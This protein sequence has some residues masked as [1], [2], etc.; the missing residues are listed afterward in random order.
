MLEPK[1]HG[2]I[3]WQVPAWHCPSCGARLMVFL[4]RKAERFGCRKCLKAWESAAFIEALYLAQQRR[5][6]ERSYEGGYGD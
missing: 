5:A 1:A 2:L 4:D 6:D 3:N